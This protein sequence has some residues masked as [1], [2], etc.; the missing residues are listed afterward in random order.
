MDKSYFNLLGLDAVYIRKQKLYI[1]QP[2]KTMH[3][4][5]KDLVPGQFEILD[6]LLVFDATTGNQI[7][8]YH[9]M[10][11]HGVVSYNSYKRERLEQYIPGLYTMHGTNIQSN[12]S[13]TVVTDLKSF[14]INATDIAY[15]QKITGVGYA[16]QAIRML[17]STNRFIVLKNTV[18]SRFYQGYSI[19]L[20]LDQQK[21]LLH[22]TWDQAPDI[23]VIG[24]DRLL[25][26]FERLAWERGKHKYAE[27]IKTGR[28][29]SGYRILDLRSIDD[30]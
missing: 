6:D 14:W 27:I 3:Q 25:L 2:Y 19:L 15:K 20:D 17:D 8:E 7:A 18:I 24:Q 10:D 30:N 9:Y 1:A 26:G 21:I 23:R 13:E 12:R 5:L 29:K 11:N 22:T 4:P 16:N 28:G